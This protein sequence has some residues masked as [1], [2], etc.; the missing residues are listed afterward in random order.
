MLSHLLPGVDIKQ[1][2]QR[3]DFDQK[4]LVDGTSIQLIVCLQLG[5]CECKVALL[6]TGLLCRPGWQHRGA[7]HLATAN[8][9]LWLAVSVLGVRHAGADLDACMGSPCP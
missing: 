6:G 8:Q 5:T 2:I 4:S 1:L 9:D 3:A 7:P